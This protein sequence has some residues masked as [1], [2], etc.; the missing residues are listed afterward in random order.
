V[1]FKAQHTLGGI[2]AT[3]RYTVLDASGDFVML[4]YC[5]TNAIGEFPSVIVLGREPGKQPSEATEAQ[6]AAAL[7]QSGVAHLVPPLHQL[8]R[9]D[10]TT[11]QCIH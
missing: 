5:Y 8:C 3:E 9:P 2:D 11:I 1:S 10:Y 7:E 6:F 4:Q